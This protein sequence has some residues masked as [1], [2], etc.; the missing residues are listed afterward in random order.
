[1]EGETPLNP[2]C[3]MGGRR[4]IS[5]RWRTLGLPPSGAERNHKADAGLPSHGHRADVP[6]SQESAEPQSQYRTSIARA[7]ST[8]VAISERYCEYYAV[9]RKFISSEFGRSVYV[10]HR[11][12][13]A[14]SVYHEFRLF[15]PLLSI[16]F[17]AL[18]YAIPESW[19]QGS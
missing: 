16:S 8:C 4:K 10:L 19:N 6:Q 11:L 5:G 18:K 13:S 7:P 1:M 14:S 12:S 3:S 9:A 15:L 17:L 2:T